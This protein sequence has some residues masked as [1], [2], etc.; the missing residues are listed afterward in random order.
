MDDE[1]LEELSQKKMIYKNKLIDWKNNRDDLHD[2]SKKMAK[3]RDEINAKIR[4]I[5]NQISDHKKKRDDYNE[6]VKHAK[7]QRNEFSKIILN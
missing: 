7:E 6:R 2:Q 5:R 3:E 1:S 4:Q